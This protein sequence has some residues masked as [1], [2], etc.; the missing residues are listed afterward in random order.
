VRWDAINH[1]GIALIQ[2]Q[3]APRGRLQVD[4]LRAVPKG[5]TS[6]P[7]VPTKVATGPGIQAE[8]T[9]KSGLDDT[10][11]AGTGGPL[12][13]GKGAAPQVGEGRLS[14]RSA[15]IVSSAQPATKLTTACRRTGEITIE[16]WLRPANTSQ[17][18]PARIITLSA[19]TG[20]RNFTLGQDGKR[21]IVRLR[22][23][24]TSVNGIPSLDGPVGSA[25]T[26][27]AYV[28][29]TRDAAGRARLY[30]NAQQAAAADVP[31]DLSKW[32]GK[33]RLALGNE[34]T[35][36]RPWLGDMYYVAIHNTA[37][38]AAQ[39]QERHKSLRGSLELPPDAR[40]ML[41]RGRIVW[42]TRRNGNWQLWAM[43][44]DGENKNPLTPKDKV[45][46]EA[47]FSADGHR[48]LFTRGEAGNRSSVWVMDSDG[49]DPRKL[50]NDAST[51]RWRKGE[52]AVQFLRRPNRGKK[53]WQT[54]EYDLA[55]GQERL[56]FP[57]EGVSYKPELWSATGNDAGTRFV[58]WSPRPRGTWVLSA[59]GKVQ[60]HVHGGCEGTVAAD[61]RFGYGVKTAGQFIRFN[62]SD[63]GDSL[64]F[65]KREGEWSHT[66]F[67]CV[68]RDGK[69]LVYGACPPNQHDHDT[70][71]YEIF[72]VRLDNWSTVGEPIRLTFDKSTDRMPTVYVAPGK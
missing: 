44:L 35:N 37:L 62:T 71:D 34:L 72:I 65:N 56:L 59:D 6:N 12:A 32:D 20:Q 5:V 21:Y 45:S 64:V 68:S 15:G 46:T 41:P 70:S 10:A 23:T 39:I 28:V 16:A 69:W 11:D 8:Y 7:R 14:F 3:N 29:Y 50:I 55:S 58:A 57:R 2:P 52:S 42:E 49:G 25:S 51:P 33:Y 13:P 31:G 47:S 66:Y 43:D 4:N 27:H 22:T 54:W 26:D 17:S 48:L 19:D 67:P 18:G 61:Q 24:K 38:S 30:V 63:G 36:D 60:A 9:F 40:A 53:F 1:I